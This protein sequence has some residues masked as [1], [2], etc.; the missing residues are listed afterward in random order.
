MA[1]T[2]S[3]TYPASKDSIMYFILTEKCSRNTASVEAGTLCFISDGKNLDRLK[4]PASHSTIEVNLIESTLSITR[5]KIPVN[6]L[7]RLTEHKA[8]LLYAVSDVAERWNC[9]RDRN[10]LEDAAN[11]NVG[12]YVVVSVQEEMYPAIIRYIG[13]I[14]ESSPLKKFFFGVEL[15]DHGEGEGRND[16]S[17]NLRRF[18]RCK[19]N[20][21]L[22]VPFN[23][24][25]FLTDRR[26][27]EDEARSKVDGV[28]P[29]NCGD[30]VGFYLEDGVKYGTVV[31]LEHRSSA[32]ETLVHVLLKE[33]DGSEI[34]IWP[35]PMDSIIQEELLSKEPKK[36]LDMA[37]AEKPLRQSSVES[38]NDEL[39]ADRSDSYFLDVNSMVQLDLQN[40]NPA[41]GII[42]WTGFL[43]GLPHKMAGVELDEDKGF[44]DGTW[45][46]KRYFECPL[47]RGIFVKQ[48]ACQPD[49]RFHASSDALPLTA[50]VFRGPTSP[51]VLENQPPL[52]NGTAVLVL[53]GTMKGIQGHCNS[54]YMDAALFSLF[55]CTSVLD[56]MLFMP[57]NPADV[58]IQNILRDEIVNPLRR[59]GFVSA[60]N[61][62]K[63]RHHLTKES[64]CPSFATSE[65]D[66]EEFLNLIMHHILG[67]EPLLKLQS[68]MQKEQE[69]YCYQIFMEKQEDMVVPDV[70]QLVAHSFL[71]SDLKLAEIP[72]CFIIQMP[73]FGKNYKMFSK[74]IPSLE[75][76]IT[77]LLFESSHSLQTQ[78]SQ[79]QDIQKPYSL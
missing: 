31:H 12:Q 43:D 37:I 49:M 11:A 63:L 78:G 55:S 41:S 19:K 60:N 47:K 68:G 46:G 10:F 48:K 34:G 66:P 1:S 59:N 27:T 23:R 62:M 75:L 5:S 40:G 15:Q 64:Q 52:T 36:T 71:S 69:C 7:Q 74:I 24:I 45:K 14:H 77:D 26:Y 16:G 25:N 58:P 72:S 8:G 42:R 57:A 44:T 3:P 6:A 4:D 51:L 61:V 29:I 70:Q 32:S 9:F 33:K 35:I 2:K 39:E 73:R 13:N 56:S 79:T 53:K 28:T 30:R 65:K 21:G 67:I 18:F 17:H 50:D 22:F 54:C 20:C 76:D 38:N